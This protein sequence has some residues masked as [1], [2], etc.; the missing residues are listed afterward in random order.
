VSEKASQLD[1]QLTWLKPKYSVLQTLTQ[2]HKRWPMMAPVTP[3]RRQRW[4]M[5]HI[6]ESINHLLVVIYAFKYMNH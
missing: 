6:L 2:V 5:I 3:D 1:L 4:L